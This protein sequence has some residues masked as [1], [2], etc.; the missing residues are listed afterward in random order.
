MSNDLDTTLAA[1]ADPTRRQ[2]VELLRE[3]PRRAGELASACAMSNPAMSRHLRVLRA[4]GLVEVEEQQG[5]NDARYRV[6]WLRSDPFIDLQK[7]L[8]QVQAF[9]TDQLGAFK[10]Y[11]E[12]TQK[13]KRT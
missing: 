12:R 6:Y 9:W 11:A 3:R 4:S 1:L 7:W 8:D 2:V 5:S 10:D 13:G